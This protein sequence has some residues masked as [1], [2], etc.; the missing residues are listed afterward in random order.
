MRQALAAR[1][2]DDI[3]DAD[4]DERAVDRLARAELLEEAEEALPSRLIGKGVAVLRRVAAGGVEQ[5][6]LVG[7][8]PVAIARTADPLDGIRAGFSRQPAIEAGILQC[9]VLPR[10]AR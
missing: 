6:R 8:P 3:G 4:G 5:H 9:L 1:Q 2:P 10:P 7:E